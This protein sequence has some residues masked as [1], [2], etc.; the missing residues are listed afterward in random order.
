[1][2]MFVLVFSTVNGGQVYTQLEEN[3]AS[4]SEPSFLFIQSAQ[5]GALSQINDTTYSLELNDIADKTISFSDRPDRIV[6]SIGTSEFIGN[7]SNK[8]EDCFALDPPNAALVVLDNS[9]FTS[10]Q[11][12]ALV[13]LF[14]PVYD[15]DRNALTY[16]AR[17]DNATSID[18]PDEFGQ[19]VMII[20]NA[21]LLHWT[22]VADRLTDD[23]QT[24]LNDTMN[25]SYC[26]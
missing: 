4:S 11:E 3:V 17:P 6:E 14:D 1:M 21:R 16:N 12:L 2:L 26:K 13:E 5:S 10:E 9:D 15:E 8:S 7:W 23:P 20:D 18:L 22:L 24:N 19:S 25:F